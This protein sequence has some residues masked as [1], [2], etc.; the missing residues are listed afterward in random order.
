MTKPSKTLVVRDY[1]TRLDY[2][3]LD[4]IVKRM[5]G[6]I[7]SGSREGSAAE[8]WDEETDTI[9]IFEKSGLEDFLFA[10]KDWQMEKIY[11][12]KEMAE[13][14]IRAADSE[15]SEFVNVAMKVKAQGFL[16]FLKGGDNA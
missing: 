11:A 12:A 15:P 4:G 16:D 7:R 14:V 6:F 5:S 8:V 1:E 13:Y 10:I 3:T 2:K 9:Y